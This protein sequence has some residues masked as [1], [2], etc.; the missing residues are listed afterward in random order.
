MVHSWVERADFKRSFLLEAP[1]L[2]GTAIAAAL[3]R[4]GPSVLAAGGAR[5][6]PVI[7]VCS[8]ASAF[9]AAVLYAGSVIYARF[10][11]VY[12][13]EP[14]ILE[15]GDL[16]YLG[17]LRALRPERIAKGCRDATEAEPGFAHALPPHGSEQIQW[18]PQ[19]GTEEAQRLSAVFRYSALRLLPSLLGALAPFL[20][21]RQPH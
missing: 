21:M 6:H 15:L 2:S 19:V 12:E 10:G 13:D 8:G 18:T 11:V 4:A 5:W 20:V 17:R 1:G 7:I 9:V 14:S 16:P 3:A